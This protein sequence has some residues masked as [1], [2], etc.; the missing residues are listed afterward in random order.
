[1]PMIAV[2]E[3]DVPTSNQLKSWIESAAPG[4]RIDQWFT[5]DDAEAAI[6]RERYDV[7]VLDIELGRER[8]AGVALINAI[9]K[10]HGT[11]VLVV[12]AMPATIY[13]SIMKA[14]DAWDY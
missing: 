9:N 12:S 14:L 1:M 8:H 7:I 6:A 3:D 10:Q 11:P 5:R 13:R 2:I 4:I